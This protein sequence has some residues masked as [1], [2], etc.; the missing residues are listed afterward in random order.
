MSYGVGT[1]MGSKCSGTMRGRGG[2]KGR[3]VVSGACA[4]S[5]LG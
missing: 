2:D 3:V 1:S 4:W 5:D